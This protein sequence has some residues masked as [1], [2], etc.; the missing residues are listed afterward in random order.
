MVISYYLLVAI[1]EQNRNAFSIHRYY[2]N[3]D[4][5][6]YIQLKLTSLGVF[7]TWHGAAILKKVLVFYPRKLRRGYI[8][9]CRTIRQI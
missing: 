1:L 5:P 3:Y 9:S 4:P 6:L 7:L 2:Y 8:I